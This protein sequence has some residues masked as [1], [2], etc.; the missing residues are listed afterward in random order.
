M[1]SDAPREDYRVD[2]PE[3][4][5]RLFATASPP[6]DFVFDAQVAR[7]FADM[8]RRSV[9]GWPELLRMLGL[10]GA[11]VQVPG[12]PIY[13]LGWSLGATTASLIARLP[14]ARIIAVDNA[15][16]MLDGL[17]ERLPEPVA[18]GRVRPVLADVAT[19][20]VEGA[21]LV[22][23]NLTLQFVE[24][25]ARLDLL[26]RLRAGLAP[27]AA[28]ILVEKVVWPD[29]GTDALMAALYHD[30]KRAQ[31]YSDMEIARKRAALDEILVPDDI[32]THE[33]RLR[34]VGFRRIERWYQCL[35]FVG[36]L[37]R[38]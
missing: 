35:N 15:P 16:A 14:Q 10:L 1:S 23:L 37:A 26:R 31:G 21:G 19:V 8:L 5:D 7:V 20:E 34:D 6:T 11:R 18:A 33:H 12:R 2:D 38:D 36:W 30:F 25:E 24:P 27:G 32:E 13:D 4:T 17:R 22:V 3:P 28:L 29:A 9:P